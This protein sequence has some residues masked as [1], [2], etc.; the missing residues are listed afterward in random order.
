VAGVF[1]DSIMW[2]LS[3]VPGGRFGVSRIIEGCSHGTS[4]RNASHFYI[5]AVR[6]PTRG[7]R[8]PPMRG[9]SAFGTSLETTNQDD[10]HQT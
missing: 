10:G 6:R 9:K 4:I 8:T 3:G 5:D 7:S 2:S 1:G